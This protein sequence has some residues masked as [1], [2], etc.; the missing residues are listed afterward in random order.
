MW[1]FILIFLGFIV[2]HLDIVDNLDEDSST[3]VLNWDKV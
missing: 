2:S 1:N 3:V